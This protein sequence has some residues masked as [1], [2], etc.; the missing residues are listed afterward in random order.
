MKTLER[1]AR[2][3]DPRSVWFGW[4][5]TLIALAHAVTLALTPPA[6]LMPPVI[7][8]VR[9]PQCGSIR[10]VSA[11][12]LGGHDIGQEWRRW[13]MVALLLLVAS[14]WRPRWTVIPHAWIT[15][16]IGVSISLPDGGESIARIVCLLIIPLGLADDRI[17]HWSRPVTPIGPTARGIAFAAFLAVRLQL[18]ILYMQSG[19]SKWGVPDWLN[20]S[21]EFYV[22]RSPLFGVAGPLKSLML[23]ASDNSLIEAG[24]TWGAIIIEIV[25]A[26]F[27]LSSTRWRRT[28]FVLDVALHVSIIVTMGLWSFAL[29]MMGS[30]AIAALPD[31][32]PGP[33]AGTAEDGT[34]PLP[35]RE[36]AP[37]AV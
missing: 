34:A 29:I 30:A 24:M 17:W 31:R 36:P 6:Y 19:V 9:A 13:I 25:I 7:D 5:R 3:F 32:L 37:A 35:E 1:L 33:G 28:A 26:V 11:Y 23:W 20:G 16:S 8:Q 21:A 22:L 15:F 10:A 2:T 12:C 27:L 4:G 14:G 18:A